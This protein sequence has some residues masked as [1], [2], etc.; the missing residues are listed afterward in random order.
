MTYG[1]SETIAQ[2]LDSGDIEENLNAFG[3]PKVAIVQ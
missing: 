2:I 3:I 1:R